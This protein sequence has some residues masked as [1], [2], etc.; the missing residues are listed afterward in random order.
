MKI[1]IQIPVLL[2]ILTALFSCKK[3]DPQP[4][5]VQSVKLTDI[6][7]DPP[8]SISNRGEFEGQTRKYWLLDIR[9]GK[10]VDNKTDSATNKWHFGFRVEARKMNIITNGGSS[11]PGGCE[12]RVVQGVFDTYNN[13][14]AEGYASDKSGEPA[15]PNKVPNSW[16]DYNMTTHML[17]PKAGAII[18][19]K[20]GEGRYAKMEIISFY[21]GAPVP[22][23][24]YDDIGYFTLRY[25][26]Q[27]NQ[28]TAF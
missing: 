24:K 27:P 2:L 1:Q 6:P 12:A 14:P 23:V 3:K 16:V 19:L 22:P 21:K 20:T 26:Y 11:G 18:L 25:V 5:P 17:T 9:T 10:Q 4:Q 7:A 13:A 28:S 15:I 8:K